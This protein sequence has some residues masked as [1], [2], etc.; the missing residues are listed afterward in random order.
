[1]CNYKEIIND[2][3]ETLIKLELKNEVL[4]T[5]CLFDKSHYMYFNKEKKTFICL[6]C[7][8]ELELLDLL[9][10]IQED[11][12]ELNIVS[13]IFKRLGLS[14]KDIN[15][16]KREQEIY[17][18]LLYVINGE[19]ASFFKEQLYKNK[20]ALNYLK[21]RNI[22]DETID[23]FQLGYAPK[24][25][26]LYRFLK[27]NFYEK[28]LEAA[29]L[30]QYHEK[31][32]KY[33]DFFKD[34]ITFSI[35]DNID[36][37]QET[38]GFGGRILSKGKDP[39]KYIN[40]KTTPIFKKSD[41]LYSF[42]FIKD[43]P[44]QIIISEG[45]MDVIA[46]HQAGIDYAVATLGTALT[47]NHYKILKNKCDNLTAIFDGD[48]AGVKA[49]E[50][51]I[52]QIGKFNILILP[53]EMDPDDYINKYGIDDYLDFLNKKTVSFTDYLIDKFTNEN[54]TQN[55][56]QNIFKQLLKLPSINI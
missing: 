50:K 4:R 31:T 29:G 42:N 49:A 14:L 7:N 44:K 37:Q 28:N 35:L 22:T 17:N 40:T 9:L 55:K 53:K 30:I 25:N 45:Y 54:K 8:F 23:K 48:T 32:K 33:S 27:N 15:K 38:L 13:K 34:R 39:R 18:K 12:E 41:C 19:A 51:A 11:T 26:L 5:P 6:A 47:H 24:Y 43:K 46:Q 56:R 20:D 3:I 52:T 16:L 10:D 21:K 36:G 1:M 2:N